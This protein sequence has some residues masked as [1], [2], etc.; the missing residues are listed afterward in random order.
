VSYDRLVWPVLCAL[1]LYHWATEHDTTITAY[2]GAPGAHEI[3]YITDPAGQSV[4]SIT[5][6]DDGSR[7]LGIR[8]GSAGE[9]TVFDAGNWTCKGPTLP[10][11]GG[12]S[13]FGAKDG[14]YFVENTKILT[15]AESWLMWKSARL[16]GSPAKLW[17]AT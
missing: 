13:S 11:L 12:A 6:F 17:G 9:C 14:K 7:V 5:I 15:P 3:R 10:D 1:L 2:F 4:R 8:S 16:F